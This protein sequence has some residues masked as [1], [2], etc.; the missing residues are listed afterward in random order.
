MN[1]NATPQDKDYQLAKKLT[2]FE[3]ILFFITF[4]VSSLKPVVI[5]DAVSDTLFNAIL[6]IAVILTVG[7]KVYATHRLR[8]ANDARLTF[9]FDN[10][11]GRNVIPTEH[12]PYYDNEETV[13]GLSKLFANTHESAF[14]THEIVAP[15]FI[16]YLVMFAVPFISL[17][18]WIATSGLTSVNKLF[19]LPILTGKLFFDAL[20]IH[21]LKNTS[22]NIFHNANRLCDRYNR[23]PDLFEITPDLLLLVLQ[24]EATLRCN[25]IVLWGWI[26]KKKRKD[27]TE[28]WAEIRKGYILYDFEPDKSKDLHDFRRR[29]I[30]ILPS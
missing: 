30:N 16:C 18:V 12:P 15:M 17:I 24:Y 9:L 1:K 4:F 8:A 27:L 20:Q 3:H 6:I 10:S 26:Y 19:V 23:S 29:T 28:K 2:F 22:E 25:E 13:V 7:V 14:F 21:S 5:P 11:F